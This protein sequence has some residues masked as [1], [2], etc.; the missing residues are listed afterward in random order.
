MNEGA[1]YASSDILLFLHADTILPN[2]AF[3]YILNIFSNKNIGA[4]AF[5]LSF[6]SNKLALKIIAKTASIRSRITKIPYG[7]QAIF[8][9][10]KVF[11]DIGGYENINLMEDVNLMQKLKR[12]KYKINIL[13]YKIITSSRKWKQKGI[14]FTTARNWILIILYYLKIDPNKL[15]NFYK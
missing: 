14:F 13:K 8:I 6:D 7:D 3:T 11:E 10:K 12:K 9:R 2:N 4:G 1:K 15:A 5:D